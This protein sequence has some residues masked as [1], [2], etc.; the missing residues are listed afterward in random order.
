M[1]KLTHWAATFTVIAIVA[2]LLGFGGAAG[3]AA[4]VAKGLFWFS[5][6]MIVLS[7]MSQLIRRT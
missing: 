6:G 5:V 3:V 4:P 1:G 2:A 7:L